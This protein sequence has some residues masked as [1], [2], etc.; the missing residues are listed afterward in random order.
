MVSASKIG[1]LLTGVVL[2]MYL[3]GDRLPVGI[4]LLD[5]LEFRTYDMRMRSEGTRVPAGDVT[6]AAIDEKS[7]AAI[8]RWPWSRR[9]QAE[10]IDKLDALGARVIALDIFFPESENSKLLAHI[11]RLE[12]EQGT[13]DKS[14]PYESIKRALATDSTLARA[15]TNSGKVILSIVLLSEE[16]ARGRPAAEAARTLDQVK[17]QAIR[18][19]LDS[20]DGSLDFDMPR[21]FGVLANLP[22]IQTGAKYV[23]HINSKPD[24][25]GTVRRAPLVMRH[26]GHFLPS[27]DVQ[28]GASVPGCR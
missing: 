13:A 25:D 22:E 9:T 24:S 16:E 3:L 27:A 4:Q 17:D 19:I 14:S 6:I 26:K 18:A 28:A 23:G 1:F 5:V 11:G 8:G 2:I 12:A 10:L 20:G 15:I 7:L 21:T